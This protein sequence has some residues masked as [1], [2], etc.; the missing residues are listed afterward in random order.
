LILTYL[1]FQDYW[2]LIAISSNR[3]TVKVTKSSELLCEFNTVYC[4][5]NYHIIIS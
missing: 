3:F 1:P 2:D 5:G 4:F